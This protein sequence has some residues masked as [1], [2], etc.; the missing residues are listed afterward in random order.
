MVGE[1]NCGVWGE[2][3]SGCLMELVVV[4]DVRIVNW[5]IVNRG[6]SMEERI[7]GEVEGGIEGDCEIWEK[8]MG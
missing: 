4:V 6:R 1:G 2:W 5:V 3:M 8:R 7:M